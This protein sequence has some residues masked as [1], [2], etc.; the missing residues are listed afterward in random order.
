MGPCRGA[1]GEHQG[2]QEEQPCRPCPRAV[3]AEARLSGIHLCK[4][5]VCA[6]SSITRLLLCT[7]AD[8]RRLGALPAALQEAAAACVHGSRSRA[9]AVGCPVPLPWGGCACSQSSAGS[10]PPA[11][12]SSGAGGAA[13]A[14]LRP[15]SEARGG[16]AGGTLMLRA[17]PF[18]SRRLRC[19]ISSNSLINSLPAGS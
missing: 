7:T 2:C 10:S 19:P 6:D 18:R 5:G 13:A 14:R 17:A 3:Q 15:V 16:G 1:W 9:Q 4:G 12:H 8:L 11:P